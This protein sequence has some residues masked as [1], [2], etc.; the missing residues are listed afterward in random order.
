MRTLPWL[1]STLAAMLL[2]A[3]L[4]AQHQTPDTLTPAQAEKIAEAGIDPPVRVE[5][6]TKFLDEHADAIKNLAKRPPS[7]ARSAHLSDDLE[8]FADLMDEL[9]SN[10][11]MY[12]DRKADI[13]KAMKPL[14]ESIQKW[15]AMLH[16]LADDQSYDLSRTDAI[17]SCSDLADQSKQLAKDQEAYFK[18]HKD[19]AGQQRVM[20]RPQ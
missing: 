9:G 12:S 4:T 20:P 2:A 8:D 14:N 15:Q 10:L 16:G 3:P 17:D 13:R 1:A 18:E 19:Q 7:P 11:D 5:L 6:Y